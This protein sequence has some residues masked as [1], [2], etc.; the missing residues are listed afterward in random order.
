MVLWY[1]QIESGNIIFTQILL[2]SILI[3]A[4]FFYLTGKIILASIEYHFPLYSAQR[5]WHDQ[6]L[7][8]FELEAIN[9]NKEI[10][11]VFDPFLSFFL[12][13]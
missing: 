2:I 11:H 1:T 13:L 7:I 9:M 10:N 6:L 8:A 3:M 5:G 12:I 4:Y